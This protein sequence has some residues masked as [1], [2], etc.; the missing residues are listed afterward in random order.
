[1][2]VPGRALAAL[3][4]TARAWAE[5]SAVIVAK[6]VSPTIAAPLPCG[7]TGAERRA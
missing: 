2:G 4:A 1:M 6:S 7:M 5:P 3:Q